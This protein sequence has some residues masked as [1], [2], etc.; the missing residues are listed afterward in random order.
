[1][2]KITYELAV[3]LLDEMDCVA[4]TDATG[5][6]IYQN[7]LWHERR[8]KLGQDPNIEYPWQMLKDSAVPEVLRTK[9]RV[10]G[11]LLKSG[12]ITICVNYYPIFKGEVF[13]GVLIW[14]IFTGLGA[15][16]KF[17]DQ[18]GRLSA[19]LD[20]AKKA[21]R[22]LAAASYGISNIVGKSNAI[23]ALKEQI[24]RVALT[25]S[26]VLIHGETGVG[27]ELVAHAIHDLSGRKSKRF[28]RVNCSAIPKDLMEAEFFGYAPGSFTG[29]SR[30]GKAGKFELASGGSLFLDEVNLLPFEMQP[31][32]LR[33]LQE[34]EVERIGAAC[35]VPVDTRLI[36]ATNRDLKENIQAGNFRE[37]LYYRL[38]VINITVP[39]LRERKEDIPLLVRS[40]VARLS[41][42]M[43][44]DISYV[45]DEA[46]DVLMKYDWPGNIRE[47]QNVIE[48]AMN[49]AKADTIGLEHIKEYFSGIKKQAP[50]AMRQTPEYTPVP[51]ALAASREKSE[52]EAI[53]AALDRCGNNRSLAARQLGIG[54]STFYRKLRQY[55]LVSL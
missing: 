55:G 43:G 15:V 30:E 45:D 25:N 16:Q 29:A 12:D 54:R 52:R 3:T 46:I 13:E 33:V 14:T 50:A 20:L 5:R 21:N 53:L 4:M 8:Q 7:R 51:A 1:M 36:A 38:N 28:V 11:R 39:P 47:L 48:Q 40:L 44:L 22:T 27:K 9:K 17:V 34:R 49:Y 41:Y 35:P 18:V 31:K 19:E 24:A 32:L 26:S 10:V 6:Y 37:D 42:Q 2:E 23:L